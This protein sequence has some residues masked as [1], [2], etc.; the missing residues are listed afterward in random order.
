MMEFLMVVWAVICGFGFAM[1]AVAIGTIFLYVMV[2]IINK[3]DE[4]Y[5]NKWIK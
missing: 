3:I 4:F 2:W 1:L 5:W